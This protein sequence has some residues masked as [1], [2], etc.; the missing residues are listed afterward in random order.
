MGQKNDAE[1]VLDHPFFKGKIDTQALLKKEIIA[2]YLPLIDSTG[3]NNFDEDITNQ[4]AEET[5]IPEE[6]QLKVKE[7]EDKFKDF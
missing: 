4:K 3:I 1:E 7:N 5:M 2:D 6:V